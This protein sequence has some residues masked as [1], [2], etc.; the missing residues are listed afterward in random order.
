MRGDLR[1]AEAELGD[2]LMYAQRARSTVAPPT[3]RAYLEGM[4]YVE[5]SVCRYW[6]GRLEDALTYACEALTLF[7]Q[8]ED[9]DL[10]LFTL[11]VAAEAAHQLGQEALAQ[12]FLA[13]AAAMRH[14]SSYNNVMSGAYAEAALRCQALGDWAAAQSH[15]QQSEALFN[16]QCDF[17]SEILLRVARGRQLDQ[18][19]SFAAATGE[20][21]AAQHKAQLHQS[22]CHIAWIRLERV[23]GL[24]AL[25]QLDQVRAVLL[26]A[27][28][29][30]EL[31]D[32]QLN[33]GR[34][35]CA[36]AQFFCAEGNA[37]GAQAALE[38]AEG[39]ARRL[40]A[41]LGLPFAADL[42]R[43]RHLVSTLPQPAPATPVA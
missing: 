29:A 34:T 42:Q 17:D 28:L 13:R 22:R 1:A 33:L 3:R 30:F 8:E 19:G 27:E 6:L 15:L 4:V 21:F 7:E 9:E 25:G 39:L 20:Y 40:G 43:A 14:I 16:A 35:F 41:A 31:F 32:A 23:P 37:T 24:I 26:D 38:R 10:Q 2:A 12:D 5:Y 11:A 18:L 36:W